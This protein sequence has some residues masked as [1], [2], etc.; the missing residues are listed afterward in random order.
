MTGFKI[1]ARCE[2]ASPTPE[3]EDILA[4]N[5]LLPLLP[6]SLGNPTY[7]LLALIYFRI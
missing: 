1:Y 3:G 7:C 5:Y 6:R 4:H 2:A